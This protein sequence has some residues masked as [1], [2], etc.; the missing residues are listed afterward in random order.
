M[1]ISTRIIV[2]VTGIYIIASVIVIFFVNYTMRQQAI[3]DAGKKAQILLNHNLALHTYFS[4]NLKPNLFKA[5]GD[6]ISPDYFDPVWMSSTYAVRQIDGYSK[7]L[8][9]EDYYYK[10]CAVN[11]RTNE[12]EADWYERSFIEQLNNDSALIEKSDIRAF[13]N[14][15]FFVSMRRGEVLEKSCIRCHSDPSYAPRGMLEQYGS[16]KGFNRNLGDVVSAVSIRI[17]LET[18]YAN[19][20]KFSIS[21]SGILLFVLLCLSFIYI[22]LNKRLL[23]TPIEAIR[24]KADEISTDV[25]KVGERIPLSFGRELNQLAKAFNE[26]SLSLRRNSEELDERVRERTRELSGLNEKLYN[27]ISTRKK[28]ESDLIASEEKF[29]ALYESMNEAVVLHRLIYDE[30]NNAVNYEILDVNPMYEVMIGIKK[31]AVVGKTAA[32]LYGTGVAPYFDVYKEVAASGKPAL[33]ETYFK[34]LD[35]HFRVSVFSPGGGM[36]ATVTTDI[37]D[38]KKAEE[39]NKIYYKELEELNSS[40]DKLFSLIAHDLRSPFQPLLGAAEILSEDIDGL[41]QEELQKI[42]RELY[43]MLRNQYQLLDNLLKWAMFQTGRI[44]IVPQPL[45]IREVADNAIGLLSKNAINKGIMLVNKIDTGINVIADE[46]MLSSIFQNLISN[47]IKFS[48]SGS[49]VIIDIKEDSEF[50]EV[51]VSDEGI[52]MTPED[53]HSVFQIGKKFTTNGTADEKGTGLG[54]LLCKEFVEK[55]G[56]ELNIKSK[57]GAGSRFS[58]TLKKGPT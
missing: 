23:F 48:F 19:A 2:L 29:R 30:N 14:K 8:S 26:M 7:L 21:L 46:Q 12:N 40:K 24:S 16:N 58:L 11:A 55:L 22:W 37:S 25:T 41:T 38:Q 56:G 15:L 18:A 20:D 57:P 43:R 52:G 31:D 51:S 4:H 5:T 44:K 45:D 39:K 33:F 10:E 17:P 50:V 35:K 32:G 6:F 53:I 49:S 28:A 27:E 47:A 54:L 1:K 9:S 3:N 36:F 34:P 13:N 42:G